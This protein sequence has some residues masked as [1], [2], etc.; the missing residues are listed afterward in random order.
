MMDGTP[1]GEDNVF[2]RYAEPAGGG[3]KRLALGVGLAVLVVMVG[4][5]LWMHGSAERAL[6]AMAP[7]QREALFKE[8][9]ENFR[10][11]CVA[12][13]VPEA[14][15][16]C[17]KQAEFLQHFP[18]CDDACRAEVAPVLRRTSR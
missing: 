6:S 14:E 17:H 12:G 16:K 1:P 8:T 15:A 13:T 10:A 3:W 7:L 11:N 2:S 4:V 9:R 18:E 5:W